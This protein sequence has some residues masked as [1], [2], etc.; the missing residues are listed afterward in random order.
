MLIT[1]P[2]EAKGEN[3]VAMTP[4]TVKRTLNKFKGV[5]IAVEK[6]AGK[7]AY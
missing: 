3:R 7:T 2:K 4:D 6:G 5:K 1:I